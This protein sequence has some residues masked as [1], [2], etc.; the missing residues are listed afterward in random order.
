MVVTAETYERIALD[1]FDDRWELLC[2]RLRKKPPMTQEHQTT[3]WWLGHLIGNQLDRRV[4]QVRDNG[5][6]ARRGDTYFI[7]DVLVIPRGYMRALGPSGP[8]E[9]YAEPLPFVAEVWSRSTGD[10]DVETK[11]PEYM[12][13]GDEEIWRI[14]PY[15][16][17]VT[18]WRRQPSGEY[19]ETVY[20]GGDVPIL[21]LPGVSIS[22]AELFEDLD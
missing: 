8:L 9:S 5:S 10:Y 17:T 15:Q 1:Q 16:R 20:R 11:F 18:A 6:R 22:L 13:R 21:S 19:T 12:R 14:D 7:P 3:A 4:H 2:G